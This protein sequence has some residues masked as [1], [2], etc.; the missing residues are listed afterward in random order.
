MEDTRSGQG[1]HD[2]MMKGQDNRR[3]IRN[4]HGRCS[5]E[6][7]PSSIEWSTQLTFHNSAPVCS[8][9][10]RCRMELDWI[11]DAMERWS[12]LCTVCDATR[13]AG[14]RLRTC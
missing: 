3:A 2:R 7:T 13:S 9:L 8:R 11:V 12:C 4:P 5:R 14:C 1:V 6:R 10:D